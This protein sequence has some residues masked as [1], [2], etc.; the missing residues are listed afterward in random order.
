MATAK[1]ILGK[2]TPDMSVDEIQAGAR[3]R[4]FPLAS[5]QFLICCLVVNLSGCGVNTNTV[6]ESARL[7]NLENEKLIKFS[8]ISR[9]NWDVVCVLTPYSGGI[10]DDLGDNRIKTIQQ[11]K[12][13]AE[14]NNF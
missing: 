11:K 6:V 7:A 13:Q 4:K 12:S 10:G 9:E 1:E 2:I 14:F 8:E 5:H 3:S